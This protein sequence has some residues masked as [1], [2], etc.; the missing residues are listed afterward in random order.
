MTNYAVFGGTNLASDDNRCS[1]NDFRAVTNAVNFAS[2]ARNEFGLNIIEGG[3]VVAGAAAVDSKYIHRSQ[4]FKPAVTDSSGTLQTDNMRADALKHSSV[5]NFKR[6]EDTSYGVLP[7]ATW[8][9]IPLANLIC[10]ASL[11]YGNSTAAA[12]ILSF[13]GAALPSK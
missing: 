7:A 4:S 9:A 3:A 10:M 6:L 8:V 2:G 13:A 5:T 1:D 11:I 12:G